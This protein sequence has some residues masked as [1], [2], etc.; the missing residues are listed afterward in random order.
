LCA[1]LSFACTA[2]CFP[3][4]ESDM[5]TPFGVSLKKKIPLFKN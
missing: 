3:W 4:Y 5:S 1:K 2:N